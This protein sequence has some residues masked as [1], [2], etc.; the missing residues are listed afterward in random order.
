MNDCG[1]RPLDR[2]AFL[3][4]GALAAAGAAALAAAPRGLMAAGGAG[5][6]NIILMIADDTGWNDVGY[7]GSEIATPNIDR[8]AAAGA[9]LDQFY[10]CPT[11]SPT[12]AAI[13]MGRP[14]CRYGIFAPIAGRSEL[15]L[16]QERGTLA[17]ALRSA[18]YTTHQLGKWHLGLRPEVGPTSFGFDTSYGYLHGQIDQYTHIYKNGDTSWHRNEQFIEEEGHATDLLADESVRII[19]NSTADTPFFLYTAFSVP[20]YPVQ[21]PQEWTARYEGKIADPDRLVY[22]ASMTHMDAAIGRIIEAVNK[23]GIA[24]NTLLVFISDNGGQD[25][26]TATANEYDNRHGPYRVLGDNRPLRGWKG[27]HYEGGIRVP[28]AAVWPGVIGQRK[29]RQLSHAMDLCATFAAVAGARLPE[30]MEVEGI[31]LMPFISGE[32]EPVERTLYWNDGRSLAVRRGPWKLLHNGSRPNTGASELYNVIDDPL[33]QNDLSAER[34]TLTAQMR[35]LL[36]GQFRK[37][38]IPVE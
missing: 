13:L 8:M 25:N 23:K 15:T 36:A 18:G 10:A 4:A 14:P 38:N 26:W 6:P 12:R 17:T 27:S 20:H 28:A 22:A 31:D 32:G 16:P 30:A 9:E 11:C 34:I 5:K 24:E 21:E 2:R 35:E 1:C 19:E 33:E 29:V 37:D 3:R 7:H